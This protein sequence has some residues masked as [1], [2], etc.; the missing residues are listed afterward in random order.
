MV[1]A[2]QTFVALGWVN[3]S[4]GSRSCTDSQR[5]HDDD[6]GA[7]Q[8]VLFMHEPQKSV[9][10]VPCKISES[11]VLFAHTR[12][13]RQVPSVIC[14]TFWVAMY[15]AQQS[16]ISSLMEL[17]QESRILFS[18]IVVRSPTTTGLSPNPMCCWRI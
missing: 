15:T 12:H 3:A 5:P 18:R 11:A 17:S 1:E 8:C 2:K 9:H 13:Q 14:L 6:E 7:C 16:A 10:R 4:T